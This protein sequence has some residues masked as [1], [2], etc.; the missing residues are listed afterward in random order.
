MN[1]NEYKNVIEERSYPDKS[2][3]WIW[4]ST[5]NKDGYGSI[6]IKQKTY[7]AHRL[8]F[9]I[10]KGEIKENNC[11]CHS[12]DNTKCVNPEHLWQGSNRENI[13]DCLKKNRHHS[14]TKYRDKNG[15]FIKR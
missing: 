10:Y 5:I 15:R 13:Y 14:Q 12:C 8:S 9:E 6:K 1:V 4:K 2:G 7:I 11:V 3:C